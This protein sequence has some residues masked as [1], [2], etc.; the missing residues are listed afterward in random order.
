M[1]SKPSVDILV[2]SL[3]SSQLIASALAKKEPKIVMPFA[4]PSEE[5]DLE[6]ADVWEQLRRYLEVLQNFPNETT[7]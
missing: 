5:G 1:I 6:R 3:E 2:Q 7:R 4:V